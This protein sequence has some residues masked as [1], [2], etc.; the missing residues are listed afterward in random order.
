MMSVAVQRQPFTDIQIDRTVFHCEF[1]HGHYNLNDIQFLHLEIWFFLKISDHSSGTSRQFVLCE[2]AI[3]FMDHSL[4]S[5]HLD[6][7]T[8]NKLFSGVW[9]CWISL[10]S[11]LQWLTDTETSCWEAPLVNTIQVPGKVPTMPAMDGSFSA[12]Q[13]TSISPEHRILNITL[14]CKAP[15]LGKFTA[16]FRQ[17][18]G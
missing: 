2:K 18:A 13:V 15:L 1:I 4:K 17:P 7:Q 8:F 10:L 12:A 11:H 5:P 16:W 9:L 3:W 6:C 14:A